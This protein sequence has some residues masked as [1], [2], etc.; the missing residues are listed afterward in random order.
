MRHKANSICIWKRVGGTHCSLFSFFFVRAYPVRS[1]SFVIAGL[2]E[3]LSALSRGSD[4]I[5]RIAGFGGF[6]R[7]HVLILSHAFRC[8]FPDE[9]RRLEGLRRFS[10]GYDYPRG[11]SFRV[12]AVELMRQASGASRYCGWRSIGHRGVGRKGVHRWDGG[13]GMRGPRR[14]RLLCT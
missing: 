14:S 11:F 8:S 3:A 10:E 9:R 1:F 6:L 7:F 13:V 5:R 2:R 12:Q 4:I